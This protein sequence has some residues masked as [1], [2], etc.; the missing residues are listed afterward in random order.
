MPAKSVISIASAARR[1]SIKRILLTQLQLDLVGELST[2]AGLHLIAHLTP[3]IIILDCAAPQINPLAV[4]P[5]LRAHIHAPQIIAL[6][7][8]N[9]AAERS[10]LRALGAAAYAILEQPGSLIE[11]LEAL[12]SDRELPTWTRPTARLGTR[13]TA[14]LAQRHS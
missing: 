13:S 3:D 6:S 7:A 11:A 4:L 9:T 12:G 14:E 2:S 1:D 10:L 8:N 5:Q